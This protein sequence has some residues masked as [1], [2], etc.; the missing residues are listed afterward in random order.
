M[1]SLGGGRLLQ[2]VIIVRGPRW[3]SSSSRP[4]PT[5]STRSSMQA[6]HLATWLH[7]S[8]HSA[9]GAWNRSR[10]NPSASPAHRRATLLLRVSGMRGI[11]AASGGRVAHRTAVRPVPSSVTLLC[12]EQQQGGGGVKYVN[13]AQVLCAAWL[14]SAVPCFCHCL[15]A[16][17]MKH[18]HTSPCKGPDTRARISI[19]PLNAADALLS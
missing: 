19:A 12:G 3:R 1:Q 16:S 9:T 8:R 6:P 15:F 11:V 5:V 10:R 18:C 4:A 14:R 13:I 2:R 17:A 7:R